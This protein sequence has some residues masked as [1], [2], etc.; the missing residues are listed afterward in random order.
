[1]IQECALHPNCTKTCNNDSIVCTQQCIPYGCECPNGTVVNEEAKECVA[2][3]ECP[4]MPP[5]VIGK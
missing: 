5:R 4:T 3:T 2:I 1:M